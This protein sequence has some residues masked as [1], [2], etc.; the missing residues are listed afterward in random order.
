[1]RVR[2]T[3]GAARAFDG[4]IE[5]PAMNFD[6]FGFDRLR[7]NG[8]NPIVTRE[9]RTRW[10]GARAFLL[11]LAYAVLLAA[12]TGWRYKDALL[13]TLRGVAGGADLLQRPAALGHELFLALA[14]L[15]TLGWM[16]LAPALTATSIAGERERGLLEAMQLSPLSPARIVSGKLLSAL[17]F[18]ALMMPVALPVFAVCFFT[19]GV[20]PQEFAEVAALQFG[21]AATGA[22][23][24]IFFSARSRRAQGALAGAF[25]FIAVWGWGSYL[26]F[27]EWANGIAGALNTGWRIPG[28]DA[29]ITF[30]GWSNPLFA[31]Y[32]VIEPNRNPLTGA[33]GALLLR[34][35][36][37]ILLDVRLWQINLAMQMLLC[38]ALLWSAARTLRKPLPDLMLSDRSWTD[39]ARAWL[40]RHMA[41]R[42]ALAIKARER[43]ATRLAHRAGN[44]LLWELPLHKFIRF[45]DPIL[46][47][48]V[49]SKFRW[50]RGSLWT[51]LFQMGLAFIGI[52][53]YLGALSAAFDRGRA[54]RRGGRWRGWDWRRPCWPQRSAAPAPSPTS[55]KAAPGTACACRCCRSRRSFAPRRWPGHRLLLLFAAAAARAGDERAPSMPMFRCISWSMDV[56]LAQATGAASFWARRMA[57]AWRGALLFGLVAAHRHRRQF[58]A[59]RP[60]SAF[61]LLPV[62]L[63]LRMMGA[64]P[65]SEI[66][67]SWHPFYALALLARRGSET[68]WPLLSAVLL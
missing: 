32:D 39:P 3:E 68:A 52:C 9:S 28:A 35:F 59:G 24:G 61:V 6:H 41:A 25:I 60:V 4:I 20:S 44:A 37:W 13:G 36:G 58:G 7:F 23:I 67:M 49:R 66:L 18:I 42:E 62:L 26:A 5:F 45:A 16:L 2:L 55:G 30:F 33:S 51:T 65:G 19:G 64:Y 56:G 43:A 54:R 31:V 14:S 11:V 15:Q 29:A 48:E 8:M 27:G 47:R 22:A 34:R 63:G 57:F 46:Q 17:S 1:M 12:A 21:T 40:A 50:R 38:G 53:V 10:R